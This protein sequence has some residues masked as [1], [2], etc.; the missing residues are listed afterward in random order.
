MGFVYKIAGIHSTTSILDIQITYMA[1]NIKK[2]KKTLNSISFHLIIK[3]KK[4][5]GFVYKIAGKCG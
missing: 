1:T 5:T 4:F 3:Q 2:K